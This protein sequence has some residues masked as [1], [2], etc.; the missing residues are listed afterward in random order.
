MYCSLLCYRMILHV[1]AST[2]QHSL[3]DNKGGDG[4]VCPSIKWLRDQLL[5]KLKKWAEN[6]E[7]SSKGSLQLISLERYTILYQTLKEKYGWDLVKV[8]GLIY[9]WV[10][11]GTICVFNIYKICTEHLFYVTASV[12]LLIEI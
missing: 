5:P 7:K 11:C 6:P 8:L 1:S 9:L 4:V 3:A 10:T 2:I 12:F